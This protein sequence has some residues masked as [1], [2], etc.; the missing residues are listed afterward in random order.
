MLLEQKS[1]PQGLAS[2]HRWTFLHSRY[3][4]TRK[5]AA[6]VVRNLKM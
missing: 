2:E 1:N 3:A 6:F 4:G 5:S